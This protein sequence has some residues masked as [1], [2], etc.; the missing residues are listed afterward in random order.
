M[1]LSFDLYWSF[2][3]PYSYLATPRLCA[4]VRDY[5]VTCNFRPVY[6]L[7]VRVEDFFQ[8]V[9]PLWPG[10]LMRDLPREAERLGMALAW[11]DPDPIVQDFATMKVAKEQPHITKLTRL[12]VAAARLGR[13]LAFARSA[14]R[15]IWGGVKNWHEGN[16]LATAAE[17]AGLDFA[18]MEAM[19][20]SDGDGL[21]RE[22][23]GNEADQK[24]AGHWGVP[25]MVFAEEPFFGQ[26]RIESLIWRLQQKG[27][28][29]RKRR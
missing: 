28:T 7:A 10:Y 1:S 6:P 23:V 16:I 27:L 24:R 17:E 15:R 19:V 13:G 18:A 29:K 25:L 21:E 12:G 11:P 3:S 9:N 22:I 5:D 20:S 4:L 26:D 2:R 14:S 8:N